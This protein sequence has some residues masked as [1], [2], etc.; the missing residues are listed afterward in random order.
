MILNMIAS[1]GGTPV[2]P[3]INTK[4]VTPSTSSGYQLKFTGFTA[5]PSWFVVVLNPTSDTQSVGQYPVVWVTYD[6]TNARMGV[7][8]STTSSAAI[9]ARMQS[10]PSSAYPR[11]TYSNGTLTITV[12]SSSS[13]NP[14]LPTQRYTMYYL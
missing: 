8:S 3:T 5:E 11:V 2:V 6:G 1:G 4:S 12:K 10:Y 14:K 13:T 9:T 7:A